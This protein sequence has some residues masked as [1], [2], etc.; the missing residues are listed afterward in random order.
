M[1]V[2]VLDPYYAC[3]RALFEGE[4]ADYVAAVERPL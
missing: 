2:F 4:A 1:D 3:V